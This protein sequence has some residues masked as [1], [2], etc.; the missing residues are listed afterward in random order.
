MY[1]KKFT[2]KIQPAAAAR[3]LLAAV[4]AAS[5]LGAAPALAADD[6]TADA[7]A[8]VI[9]GFQ[10]QNVDPLQFGRIIPSGLGGSVMINVN[11]GAVSTIGQVVTVGTNQTRARFT[12]K[13]PVGIIMIIAGDP[14]VELT[15][16]GGTESMTASLTHKGTTGLATATVFGLPIGLIATSPDQEIHTGGSLIVAGNQVEGIYEGSFALLVSYL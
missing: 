6:A 1:G 16:I 2:A 5:T 14:S 3:R 15:R 12:V 10:L 9:D 13:A 7:Q 8:V 11:T 4:L